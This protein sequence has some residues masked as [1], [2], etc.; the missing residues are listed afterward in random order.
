MFERFR[1]KKVT[2][3]P[4]RG[5]SLVIMPMPALVAVLLHHEQQ[6]GAPLTEAEVNAIRDGCDCT[7]VPVSVVP[8][9]VESRGYDDIDPEAVWEQW[10]I[11]RLQLIQTPDGEPDRELGGE[12]GGGE[13]GGA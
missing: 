4:K 5:E 11:V 8:K 7:M 1:R 9:I 12:L 13:S 3:P 10:Q 6:K 2:E